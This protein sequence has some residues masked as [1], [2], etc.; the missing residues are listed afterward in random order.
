MKLVLY[1]W[2]I[3]LSAALDPLQYVNLFIGTINGGHTFPGAT[4]PHGMVKVGMDTDSPG[5]SGTGGV[6]AIG[7]LS[8]VPLSNFKLFPIHNC[9]AFE[10]CLTTIDS[11]KIL[12]HILP[13]G[14]V[15]DYASPGYFSTNLSNSIRVELTSTR[16]TALH[17][18]TFPEES[19]T[20]RILLDVTNDGQI[21]ANGITM[22]IDAE[23]GRM[24][25]SGSF[26]DSFGIDRYKA[27]ACVDFK[28]D[29]SGPHGGL[30]GFPG[31]G[32]GPTTI[33]AR[34]GISLLSVEQAC[35]NAEGEIPDWDFERVV[36]DSEAQWRDILGRVQ[37]DTERV[38]ENTTTLLYSSLYRTHITPADL[39][40]E[41]PGWSST[42]PYYDSF[43]CN[44]DTYRTLFPLM[45][46]HDPERFSDIVRGMIDIQKNEGWLP[47]CRE[48]GTK[49]F[50]Q[51]GSHGDPILAE[52][53]IKYQN[54]TSALGVS[55]QDLYT[56]LLADAENTPPNWNIQGRQADVWKEFG[57]NTKQV[58][59]AIEYAFDDFAISQVAK[60]L[61]K[62]EDAA[63]Y[64]SRAGNFVNSWNGSI[65]VPDI[66]ED[67]SGFFQPRFANGTWNYTDPR[68]CSIHDPTGSTC[69]LNAIR[70]DGFYETSPIV[71]S[72]YAPHDTAKLIELQGGRQKFIE[73][74]DWIFDNGY[75]DSTNEPSQQIPYMYHYADKPGYSARRVRETIDKYFNT[76][77]NGLP[78]NDGA[79]GSYVFFYLA[80]MYPLPATK[81]YLLSSPYFPSISFHNPFLNSTTTIVSKG[82]GSGIYVKS[83]TV[84][85]K[86]YKSTCFLDWD[87]FTT[88]STVVLELTDDLEVSCGG[89]LPPS[90]SSG[91]Y[92]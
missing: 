17:R 56:A 63:K 82:F 90:L 86:P 5:N 46:L 47:E 75:F 80:G 71:Y 43:Y 40:G 31:S 65:I 92:D 38:G 64:T 14:S 72:Q 54:H 1:S 35:A 39:T 84:N 15:D 62:T 12:R 69:F 59:R 33:L 11:R 20:P 30:V 45:S 8:Q 88:T 28:G 37:V 27:Y 48:M 9:S 51:G 3:N 76:S 25:A 4:I 66:A 18:Y 13:D 79:M 70:R 6:C 41:N 74:L 23:T 78:G 29:F 89:E 16:R 61:K 21:S 32:V 52:F 67:I 81:Q 91:G 77:R 58:S 57:A 10:Q 85:G 73:R 44:W 60:G 34:V 55:D 68:H 24:T 50:I 22:L 7:F 19:T 36:Q 87:V 83:V 42:E 49:Q 2:L 26:A 53:F